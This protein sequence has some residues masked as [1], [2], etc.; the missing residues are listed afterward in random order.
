M[1]TSAMFLFFTVQSNIWIA[2]LAFITL[3]LLLMKKELPKEILI[4]KHMFT[5]AILLTY[6]VFTLLLAPTQNIEYLL[7]PENLFLHTF[8]PIF[9]IAD[10]FLNDQF[11][12]VKLLTFYGLITP[13]FYVV[14]AFV[15]HGM[16]IKF[17]NLDFPYFF[18][19][20][21][22]LGWFTFGESGIG[23][24]YW[25]IIVFGFVWFISVGLIAIKKREKKFTYLNAALGMVVLSTVV[26]SLIAL[27]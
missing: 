17:G 6:I 9:A 10:Y 14:F 24:A 5:V 18:L 8:T 25:M 11:K 16:G 27:N 13:F 3:V 21:E 2:G 4:F 19:D 1:L 23:V 22:T 26:T 15:I 20:Y 12:P 7:S